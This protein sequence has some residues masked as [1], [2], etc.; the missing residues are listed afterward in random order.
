[1]G[2]REERGERRRVRG[3]WVSLPRRVGGWVKCNTQRTNFTTQ[4]S[5]FTIH[6][7]RFTGNIISQIFKRL[8]QIAIFTDGSFIKHTGVILK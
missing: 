3:E 2:R 4:D 6:D 1:M 7:S 5:R 8:V